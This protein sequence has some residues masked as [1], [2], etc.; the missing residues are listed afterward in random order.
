MNNDHKFKT[1]S[2]AF[3]EDMYRI[4][5][6]LFYC[7]FKEYFQNRE[8]F[9][10]CLNRLS[11]EKEKI[12][13]LGFFYYVVTNE[14]KHAGVTLISI[15]SIMEATAENK[16]QPFDQWL[17]ARI[18]ESENISF[19]IGD[20]ENLKDT[21]LEHQEKYYANHGSSE[22]VRSFIY[23]YFSEEDKHNLIRGFQIK[24]SSHD[25]TSLSFEEQVKAIVD[26]LYKERNAFVHEGRLPQIT[27]QNDRMLGYCKIRN[28]DTYV[29]IQISIR[30]IQKMFE[31]GFV[32][33]VK[34]KGA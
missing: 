17:L 23:E 26:M 28:R 15:F 30:Q 27:D 19:P 13:R 2:D 9:D 4:N 10:A 34:K 18:K 12:I 8:D 1:I 31:K 7:A 32:N 3:A 29:S 11:N 22:K 20:K 5:S 24:D 6:D 33:F 21:I 14:I 25:L 16:F